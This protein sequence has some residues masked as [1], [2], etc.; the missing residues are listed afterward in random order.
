MALLTIYGAYFIAMTA[1]SWLYFGLMESSPWQAT[2][3]K[4]AVGIM[5]TDTEGKRISFARASGRYFA[6]WLSTLVAFVG[7]ILGAI[8]VRKQTLHDLIVRTVVIHGRSGG[9]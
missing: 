6:S 2:L 4:R 5:V 9:R 8:T 1:A 3:G 7:Y